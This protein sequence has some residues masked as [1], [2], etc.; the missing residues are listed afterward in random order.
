[1]AFLKGI[2]TAMTKNT[3][4]DVRQ[5]TLRGDVKRSKIHLMPEYC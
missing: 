2:H 3:A 5:R 1:V 4:Q